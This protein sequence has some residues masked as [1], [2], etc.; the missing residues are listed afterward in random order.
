MVIL[1]QTLLTAV[2]VLELKVKLAAGIS[3]HMQIPSTV[4]ELVVTEKPM[5]TSHQCL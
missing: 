1:P 4:L 3:H 2:N 5:I